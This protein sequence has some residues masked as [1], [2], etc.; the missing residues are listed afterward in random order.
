MQLAAENNIASLA[1]PSISKGVY[2]YPID[3]AAN[4]A[5]T[6][7]LSSLKDFT[8]IKEVIVCCYSAR[9]LEI[10]EGVLKNL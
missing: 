3:L 5:V 1:F 9:D 6:T 7:I 8:G 10:Y 2:R 4:I